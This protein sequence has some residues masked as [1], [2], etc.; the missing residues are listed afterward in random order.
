MPGHAGYFHS[1]V[2][3]ITVTVMFSPEIFAGISA[4]QVLLVPPVAAAAVPARQHEPD[5]GPA[6][7]TETAQ[8]CRGQYT[9]DFRGQGSANV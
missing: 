4:R 1:H 5:Q 3:T 6:R 8:P 9:A 7:E 2:T